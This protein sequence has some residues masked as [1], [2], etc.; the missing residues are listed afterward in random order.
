MDKLAVELLTL[1]SFY[2][3]TDGGW[4]GC[5]LS[6]VSRR[7]REASR[8]ARFFSVSLVTSPNQLEQFLDCLHEERA[9]S[10]DMI[11]RVRHLCLS[12]FGDGLE[13]APTSSTSAPVTP[14]LPKTR[15]EFLASLHRRTQHWRSAQVGLDE[16]YNRTIPALFRAVAADLHALA[17]VQ[18]QWRSASIIRC[19]FP[20]LEE[21]MLVGGD[22]SFLPLASIPADRP[23]YP[24][25]KRL[26]HVL[27]WVGK[28]VD[29]QRWAVHA[30][31]VTHLRVSR[32]DYHP[33]ST[34]DSFERVICD[35]E[36]DEEFFPHLRRAMIE[37][38]PAPAPSARLSAAHVAFRDFLVYLDRLAERARVPVKVLPPLEEPKVVPGANPTQ[39]CLER[40]KKE[41][42]ERVVGGEGCW[43]EGMG[44]VYV[45]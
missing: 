30:P 3:C 1:I 35:S 13:T 28:D 6:L 4:T 33:Q 10:P 24:S 17:L 18:V 14:S 22:P 43:Q 45:P 25:L 39:R 32:I 29:F 21:L 20:L 26:H 36:R 41:W 31:N 34:V 44:G 7:V 40:V 9:R 15:A 11:P 42:L 12:L 2:A 5:A 38:R 8:P 23:I 37:P 19:N 27:A 16:Q